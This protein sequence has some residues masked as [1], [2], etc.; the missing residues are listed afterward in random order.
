MAYIMAS[1][2][3]QWLQRPFR[4]LC[5]NQLKPYSW[6]RASFTSFSSCHRVGSVQRPF[7]WLWRRWSSDSYFPQTNNQD[8]FKL[9]LHNVIFLTLYIYICSTLVTYSYDPA[10]IGIH[11]FKF[12][13]ILRIESCHWLTAS[14]RFAPCCSRSRLPRCTRLASCR[15]R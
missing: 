9:N 4:C 15:F 11:T 5:Q 6:L 7:Y 1:V 2:G 13:I 3:I 8:V 10:I 12:R 14:R